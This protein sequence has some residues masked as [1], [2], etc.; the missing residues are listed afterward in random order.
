M[1]AW[2]FA[3]TF[4]LFTSAFVAGASDAAAF[5]ERRGG[6]GEGGRV[7][8]GLVVERVPLGCCG[9]VVVVVVVVVGGGGA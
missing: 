1:R 9:G 4:Y 3:V 7:G 2:L 5:L 8:R 6:A